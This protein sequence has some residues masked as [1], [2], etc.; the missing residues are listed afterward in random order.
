MPPYTVSLVYCWRKLASM[1]LV[2]GY[3]IWIAPILS[4]ISSL[5]FQSSDTNRLSRQDFDGIARS[6]HEEKGKK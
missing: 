2:S 1:R 5:V 6:A 3:T 4:P